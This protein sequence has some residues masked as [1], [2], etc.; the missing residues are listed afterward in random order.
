MAEPGPFGDIDNLDADALRLHLR[1]LVAIIQCAPVAMAFSHDPGCG[2]ITANRALTR[3]L[4][5]PEGANISLTPSAGHQALYRIQ[6]DGRDVAPEHLPMQYAIA[7]RTAVSSEIEIVRPDGTVLN[8]QNDIEPLYDAHGE[9]YGCVSVCVDITD[10]KRAEAALRVADRRK[11]EFLATL[12]HELRNPL[13]PIRA[14]IEVMGRARGDAGIVEQARLTME[15]QLLHLVRL[16]DELLDLSRVTQN[17]ID[18]RLDRI[19]LRAVLESAVEI[20]RPLIEASSHTLTL[21]LPDEPIW[22]HADST[23]L[24]QAFSN[25]LNN[26]AKYTHRGG[27]IYLSTETGPHTAV[28]TVADTG[29]GIPPS[30]LPRIFDMFTQLKEHGDRTLGGLGIGLALAKRFVELHGGTIEAHSEG[31]GCGSRFTIRLPVTTSAAEERTPPF[32]YALRAESP[33]RVLVA[34]DNPDAAEMLRVMLGLSGH[35]VK[36]ASDGAEAVALAQTFEPH[37]A[38]L[39]IGMP[40][41]DGYAAA[42]EI[43]ERLDGR[44]T[45]VALTGWGQDEDKERSRD[46]GFDHH[47]TKPP[48][49]GVLEHLIG[50]CSAEVEQS[51]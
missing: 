39:D 35:E 43:R 13:A 24:S 25:L 42:R 7:H 17:K 29:A 14:A 28:V 41:M 5:V 45:L 38:F 46:A 3:L 49:P 50:E 37:I 18:L 51:G 32:E 33:R 16:T 10:R 23:R 6:R 48:E 9:V 47:I 21:A 15:R 27:E 19:D 26:A 2:V 34:D 30:K 31:L 12:S 44:V 8:V 40:R 22:M 1:S 36:V 11:D 4:G 20:T